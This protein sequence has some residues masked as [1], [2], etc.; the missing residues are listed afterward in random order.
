MKGFSSGGPS[1]KIASRGEL[2][3]TFFHFC[4]FSKPQSATLHQSTI[5]GQGLESTLRVECS[6]LL[7]NVRLTAVSHCTLFLKLLW[8]FSLLLQWPS[9][10]G[11]VK[12]STLECWGSALPLSYCHWPSLVRLIDKRWL[13]WKKLFKLKIKLIWARSYKTFNNRNL[14][15]FVIS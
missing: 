11:G 6:V 14:Q 5:C 13:V 7:S 2:L 3:Y 8:S 1:G 9:L 12:P 4:L 15:V 10:A